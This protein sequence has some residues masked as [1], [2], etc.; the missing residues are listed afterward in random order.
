MAEISA[1]KQK[2]TLLLKCE[3]EPSVTKDQFSTKP[4]QVQVKL[5]INFGHGLF[6]GIEP[7]TW[8]E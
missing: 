8:R 5:V 1:T 7:G 4:K 3:T 6:V 2:C